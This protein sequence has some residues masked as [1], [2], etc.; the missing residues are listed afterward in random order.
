MQS[1]LRELLQL[2][3]IYLAL[4]TAIGGVIYTRFS[5]TPDPEASIVLGCLVILLMST[6]AQ[7]HVS[8]DAPALQARMRLLPISGASVLFA[9]D[10]AWLLVTIPLIVGFR[11][12]PCIAAGLAA[13]IMGHR[14]SIRDC[15][16][17]QGILQIIGLVVAGSG[18]Y[19]SGWSAFA[20]VV[21]A[22]A[23]SLWWSGRKWDQS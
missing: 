8:F 11:P 20:A 6:C 21:V 15:I 2:L 3:D 4:L 12:L 17:Q 10:A 1:H 7:G 13:L 19:N 14:R 22:Y 18:V 16:E 5:A 9:N 23:G